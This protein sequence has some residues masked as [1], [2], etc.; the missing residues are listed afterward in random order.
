MSLQA[1]TLER[2]AIQR[3]T[4]LGRSSAYKLRGHSPLSLSQWSCNNL[5]SLFQKQGILAK[6]VEIRRSKFRQPI[7]ATTSGTAAT[8]IPAGQC[9]WRHFMVSHS[10]LALCDCDDCM[11]NFPELDVPPDG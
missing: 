6:Q 4:S 3:F 5:T 2:A 11:V 7:R 9:F 1:A 10:R 8:H